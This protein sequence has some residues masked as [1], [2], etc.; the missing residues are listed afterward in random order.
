MAPR[1]PRTVVV[2][3]VVVLAGAGALGIAIHA[4]RPRPTPAMRGYSLAQTL[5]CFGC[6]GSGGTGGIRNPGSKEGEVPA[7]DG[8][9]AMMY[10]E[11]EGEI[12]E[13]ILDGRPRRLAKEPHATD[14]IGAGDDRSGRSPGLPLR[15][16]AYRDVVSDDE[17]ND[18]VAYYKA[19]S[20]VEPVPPE[21][22]EGLQLARRLGCFGCHGPG[23]RVGSQNPSSF[24]GYIPPWQGD[25]F[26]ELVKNE[27]ELRQ[28][29]L[30]GKIDRLEGNPVAR[31]ITRR[32]VIRMPAY[33]RVVNEADVDALVAYIHWLQTLDD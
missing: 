30:E 20:G 29:I 1:I 11:D 5:G 2:L 23:G 28:W 16:L 10:I 22:R 13:W 19:V 21:A 7:W 33:E 6:H 31:F 14:S 24:K 9:T 4:T 26:S 27:K 32:Q 18:L 17:L 12:R 25:D 15:M 3:I 8:G